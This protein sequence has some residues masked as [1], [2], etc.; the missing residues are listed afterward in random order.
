[1]QDFDNRLLKIYRCAIIDR[2]CERSKLMNNRRASSKVKNELISAGTIALLGAFLFENCYAHFSLKKNIQNIKLVEPI[3]FEPGVDKVNV[4]GNSREAKES[5]R[6]FLEV[7]RNLD[8][9]DLT[10]FYCTFK[11]GNI[12][13]KKKFLGIF[14]KHDGSFEARDC[15]IEYFTE[16]IR[17]V[18]FHELIHMAG[19]GFS[20]THWICGF[21]QRKKAMSKNDNEKIY[22]IGIALDEGYVQL[23]TERYFSDKGI[24]RGY[25]LFVDVARYIEALVGRKKME[26]M[27][28]KADLIGLVNCLS[29][30]ASRCEVLTLLVDL[31]YI[32]GALKHKIIPLPRIIA[33]QK[34]QSILK[35]VSFM[36]IRKMEMETEMREEEIQNLSATFYSVKTHVKEYDHML[37]RTSQ[38]T[39]QQM[40]EMVQKSKMDDSKKMKFHKVA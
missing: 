15:T 36:L 32:Y 1:M 27:Y 10:N 30:Y 28:F 6:E 19:H 24:K 31:D 14:P 21:H 3:S 40:T 29:K 18:I 39:R 23:L 34:Y 9:I 2:L 8:H 26:S 38:L 25:G 35:K 16:A 5:V 4:R 22:D 13:K 20:A 17:Y 33:G 37:F 12:C 11:P 7:F